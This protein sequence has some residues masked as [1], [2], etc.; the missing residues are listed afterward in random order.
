MKKNKLG[1]PIDDNPYD[2]YFNGHSIYQSKS[3]Y[4]RY[5]FNFSRKLFG[6]CINKYD[7]KNK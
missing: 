4:Y 2:Q 6:F 5:Y 7:N 1:I 3:I